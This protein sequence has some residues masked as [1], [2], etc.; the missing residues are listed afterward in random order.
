[1]LYE[2]IACCKFT[3]VAFEKTAEVRET[4]Q[5]LFLEFSIYELLSY[6]H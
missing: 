1:M 3:I 2:V 5:G 4:L 6:C